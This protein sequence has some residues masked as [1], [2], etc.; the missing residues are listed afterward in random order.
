[1]EM[2]IFKKITMALA[3]LS[4]STATL[5]HDEGYVLSSSI[6]PSS[7]VAVCWESV[8]NSTDAQR[9]WVR[10]AVA[11]TWEKQSRVSFTG[12]GVCN[13]SS[14]G[15]RIQV[16][17]EGPHVKRLGRFLNGLNNGMVLNFTYR[18]WSQSCASNAQYCSE[19]IA[20][21]E[22]G[23]A[24]GFAHEQNRGDTPDTCTED[25]QG[26]DGDIIVGEWDLDSVMNYCNPAWNGAGDLSQ[27]DIDMV[28]MFY[29]AKE[30]LLS[31]YDDLP[32]FS[33]DYYLQYNVD[34]A[35]VYGKEN[36]K[37]ARAHWD[38]YGKK[39][40]RLSSPSFNVKEYLALNSDL[41]AAYG[42]NYVS[43]INHFK[44][45]GINEGRVTS[46]TFDVRQYL[47][48]NTDLVNAF[49]KTGYLKAHIHWAQFGLKEGRR[50]TNN[51]DVSN[52]L[53]RYSDLQAVFGNNNYL[54][55]LLHWI[56]YGRIEGRNGN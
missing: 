32:V 24:L 47:S 31:P 19:V 46:R 6:W 16:S 52:Y 13:G 50:T 33:A 34:V 21:H 40:G 43:A 2:K 12:W 49:G 30:L 36:Y 11:D 48:K 29:G 25:P 7:D 39:E 17:D 10:N 23:H 5:A 35:K 38:K 22:F 56:R 37:G 26:S 51:F 18:N 15:I 55:A 42:S 20:V 41:S 27:T 53:D 8:T 3:L 45:Y 44:V 9:G 28:Q 1:M 4:A 14:K 54:A